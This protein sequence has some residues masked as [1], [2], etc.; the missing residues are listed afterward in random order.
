MHADGMWPEGPCFKWYSDINNLSAPEE[1]V[2]TFCLSRI[3]HFFDFAEEIQSFHS[4]FLLNRSTKPLM[5][6]V[7]P[8]FR[9]VSQNIWFCLSVWSVSHPEHV[10][11]CECV[12]VAL[13]K[14]T[15]SPHIMSES[16]N[17]AAVGILMCCTLIHGFLRVDW[18]EQSGRLMFTAPNHQTYN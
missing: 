17:V 1:S 13:C 15:P 8:L 7:L 6:N 16:A 14:S 12:F 11:Q 18:Q 4:T 5:P 10:L 2:Y 9:R 3:F